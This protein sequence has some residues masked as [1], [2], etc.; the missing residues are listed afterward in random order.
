MFYFNFL[1]KTKT[2]ASA[3][4]EKKKYTETNKN[5]DETANA[6]Y[7]FVRAAVVQYVPTVDVGPLILQVT[8]LRLLLE[9]LP[10]SCCLKTRPSGLG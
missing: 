2:D 5:Q 8:N 1:L 4:R 3:N 9:D 6:I 7:M 10:A